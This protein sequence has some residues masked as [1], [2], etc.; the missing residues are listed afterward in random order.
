LRHISLPIAIGCLLLFLSAAPGCCEMCIVPGGKRT[1]RD[2]AAGTEHTG[3]T[4]TKEV[5]HSSET[6]SEIRA[7]E[8]AN[9]LPPRGDT[10]IHS[11]EIPRAGSDNSMSI[12]PRD[13]D[14]VK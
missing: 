7:R 9:P 2:N 5:P 3:V 4:V 14:T 10:A 8:N 11:H 6:I 13:D 1:P 12:H